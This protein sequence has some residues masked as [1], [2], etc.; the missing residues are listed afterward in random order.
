MKIRFYT[1][2]PALLLAGCATLSDSDCLSANWQSIGLSDG[3]KGRTFD[4]I[5]RHAKACSD[6]GVIPDAQAW[7]LGRQRGL[8]VYCTPEKAYEEGSQGR[9]LSPVCPTADAR[10]MAEAHQM[11]KTWY[12]I[13]RDIDELE[14]ELSDIRGDITSLPGDSPDRSWLFLRQM[15][16]RSEIR[17]LE[18]ERLE[19]RYPPGGFG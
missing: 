17:R 8:V 10:V 4:Y 13:G 3:S 15:H 16:I 6:V 12:E 19:Y 11:G 2:V 9:A 14:R 7:E 18:R 5:N 1:L